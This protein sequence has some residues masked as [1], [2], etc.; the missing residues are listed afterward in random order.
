MT[1]D[2]SSALMVMLIALVVEFLLVVALIGAAL[3]VYYVESWF[4]GRPYWPTCT[5]CGAGTFEH[6]SS[7]GPPI[8]RCACGRS[9]VRRGRECR[10]A[11]PGGRSLPYLRWHIFRGWISSTSTTER[12]AE[13]P[14]RDADV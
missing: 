10:I 12:S 8:V 5:A 14:Y 7:A 3:A 9:Y 6:Q 1:I 2:H 11:L 4:S 13:S